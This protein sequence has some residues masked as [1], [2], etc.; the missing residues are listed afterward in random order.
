MLSG[1]VVIAGDE[2]DPLA[3]QQSFA[4]RSLAFRLHVIVEEDRVVLPTAL[5][6]QLTRVD[7][8]T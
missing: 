2:G 6:Q 5:R 4:I 1:L 3:N 8:V 7:G